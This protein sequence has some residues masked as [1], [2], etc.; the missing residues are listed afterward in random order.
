[1]SVNSNLKVHSWNV[2]GAG[3]RTFICALKVINQTHR[4]N[5]VILLE[6][7]ISG[8]E[9]NSVCDKLAYPNSIRV[10]AN[11]RSGGIWVFWDARIFSTQLIFA[12]DQHISLQVEEANKQPWILTAIYASPRPSEKHTLWDN[13]FLLSRWIDIPWLLSSDFN[14]IRSLEEKSGPSTV[15]TARKCRSFND[16][17]NK[18]ELIDLGVSGPKF[19]WTRGDQLQTFKDSRLDRSLCNLH[20]NEAFPSTSVLDLPRL[21]SDHLPL[22]TSISPHGGNY[23]SSRPFRFEA[24]W[25]T[26]TNLKDLVSAAWDSGIPF[27]DSI[28]SL[29]VKLLDWNANVFGSI[30]KKKNQLLA[31]IRGVDSR[32]MGIFTPWLAKL[33]LKLETELDKILEQEEVLWFQR[34]REKWVQFGE[35]NTT[36]FHQLVNIRRRQNKIGA[37]QDANDNWVTDPQALASL[38]FEF[39]ANLFLQE[40]IPYE[41]RLPNQAFPRLN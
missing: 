12:C 21:H 27:H 1:M 14:A 35:P 28:A 40:N 2:G 25:L 34:S 36:Y 24:A 18:A 41:D 33:R 13:L 6:P 10:E 39:I 8:T 5:F 16:R 32:M 15:A 22:L 9:V 4:P 30:Q 37:L 17:I 7:Q 20:W 19:T 11:G 3:N 23:G 31:R 38:V 29:A 26:D